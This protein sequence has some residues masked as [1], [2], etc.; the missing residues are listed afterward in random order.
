MR[1]ERL[2]NWL[3]APAG[4]LV[5]VLLAGCASAPVGT[6]GEAPVAGA[7][8]AEQPLT[9][10]ARP[11]RLKATGDYEFAVTE[12][13][14]VPASVRSDYD[15]ALT[16]LA[17]GRLRDGIEALEAVVLAAPQFTAP[18]LDLGVAYLKRGAY[19]KAEASLRTALALTPGHP[20]AANELGVVYRKTGRFVEARASFE[21]ALG[22][23]RN[24]HHAQKNLGV[25]CDLLLN[26]LECALENYLAY[27]K[28]F[29]D[30]K[31]IEIWIADVRSRMN[32]AH[33]L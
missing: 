23:F 12:S 9:R 29:P 31:V 11:A 25:L 24:Y 4:W 27:Q 7:K 17:T 19:D 2:G 20:V 10:P 28:A 14:R 16:L 15:A 21:A 1:I 22:T 6:D 8:I 26:D 3:S 5:A 30:E 13:V 33:P 32:G 18:H